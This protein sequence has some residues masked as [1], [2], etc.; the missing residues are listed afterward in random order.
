[1][2]RRHWYVEIIQGSVLAARADDLMQEISVKVEQTASRCNTEEQV[3]SPK[4]KEA[5]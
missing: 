4:A 3:F 5:A 1:M 2:D